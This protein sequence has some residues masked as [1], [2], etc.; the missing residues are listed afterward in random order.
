[1][2]LDFSEVLNVHNVR[3]AVVAGYLS[4]LFGRNRRTDGVDVVVEGF[5]KI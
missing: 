5:W 4:I 3:Y 1:M 2:I